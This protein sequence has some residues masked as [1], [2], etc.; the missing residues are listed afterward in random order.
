MAPRLRKAG[1]DAASGFMRRDGSAALRPDANASGRERTQ[2]AIHPQRASACRD[3]NAGGCHAPFGPMHP[4][5]AASAKRD[6]AQ[7][8]IRPQRASAW[9]EG[10]AGGCRPPAV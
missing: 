3:G 1:D 2:T 10:K 7:T 5:R 8:T 4:H 6:R 9:R